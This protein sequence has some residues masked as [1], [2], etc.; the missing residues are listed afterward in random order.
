VRIDRF[1]VEKAHGYLDLD[2]KFRP[3]LTFLTGINGS[4]K[5]T[6]V[7]GIVA[8][9]TPS[10]SG[11]AA[12]D[13]RRMRV[14]LTHSGAH[15]VVQAERTGA[16]IALTV[17]GIDGR[18]VIPIFTQA[19]YELPSRFAERELEFYREFHTTEARHPVLM[20][21]AQLPTPMFLDLERR[22]QGPVRRRRYAVPPDEAR[23]QY[24][25]QSTGGEGLSQA[26]ALAEEAF[27][28]F[29]SRQST[30]QV[31]LRNG[32]VTTAFAPLSRAGRNTFDLP[33]AWAKDILLSQRDLVINTLKAI[34]ISEG[35]IQ[36]FYEE[37]L[38]LL[39]RVTVDDFE[40]LLNSDEGRELF[41]K[42]ISVQPQL[43]QISAIV[44]LMN[45]Y[46]RKIETARRPI[47]RYLT[48]I[49]RFLADSSKR[50]DF[51]QTG[52]PIV[53]AGRQRMKRLDGLS[54]G[55]RQL[56]VILTH[57]AF[58]PQAGKANV[59]IIDEP[60]LSLHI[61]WQEQF[62]SALEEAGK[63]VQLVLATHSPSIILERTEACVEVRGI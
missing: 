15:H 22:A 26:V 5:T 23:F 37:L 48:S 63:D 11:L 41:G 21:L 53:Y 30:L 54:S 58:N 13:F 19:E 4:G 7:R 59:L 20:A 1:A 31:K 60:E 33:S 17:Q 47:D 52:R 14:E 9:I 50:L 10:F 51:S 38:E 62:V 40:E 39:P 2:V 18:L 46:N 36:A 12:I 34:D 24:F 25:V 16:E 28:E 55:E 43:R 57:L 61:R 44:E 29:R 35:P 8:I 42:W 6:V 32:L 3:D 45:E 27:Q 56:L 49:N